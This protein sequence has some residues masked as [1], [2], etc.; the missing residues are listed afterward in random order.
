MMS[1]SLSDA[2]P[3]GK[4]SPVCCL[5]VSQENVLNLWRIIYL[6]HFSVSESEPGSFCNRGLLCS[7]KSQVGEFLQVS[8]TQLL[9][10]KVE[11]SSS[12]PI[13]FWMSF[14]SRAGF[15][16]HNIQ[17]LSHFPP[18]WDT[19][20]EWNS[21]PRRC[22]T[23]SLRAGPE[24]IAFISTHHNFRLPFPRMIYFPLEEWWHEPT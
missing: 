19:C 13:L 20:P 23:A 16:R 17:H 12:S 14:V 22:H 4:S 5:I 15:L 24:H 6:A 21:R 18:Q 8:W 10:S 3:L 2:P 7:R 9:A 1:L 11:S